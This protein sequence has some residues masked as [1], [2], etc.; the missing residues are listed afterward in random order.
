MTCIAGIILIIIL[1]LF[2]FA[3]F[4]HKN[5]EDKD[6]LSK[7]ITIVGGVFAAL[8]L[9]WAAFTYYD[10]ALRQKELSAMGGYQEHMK[11]T[12]D[13][14]NSEFLIGGTYAEKNPETISEGDIGY[15]RYEWYVGHALSSF[16]AIL[17]VT[18]GRDEGWNRTFAGFIKGH[19][20]YIE[21]S[22]FPCNRYNAE[23]QNL[24]K[25]TL[26]RDCSNEPDTED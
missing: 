11:M 13:P 12:I 15:M 9:F 22:K 10:G 26:G 2:V 16:E 1:A 3:F 20:K 4:V 5:V 6:G 14:L 19:K 23:L 17:D 21:S 24:V 8:S 25:T 18:S 7:T